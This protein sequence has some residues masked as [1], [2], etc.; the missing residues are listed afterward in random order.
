M[1][2]LSGIGANARSKHQCTLVIALVRSS[3]YGYQM[4]HISIRLEQ[5]YSKIQFF[6]HFYHMFVSHTG[7]SYLT[8]ILLDS[9]MVRSPAT[10]STP[11]MDSISNWWPYLWRFVRRSLKQTSISSYTFNNFQQLPNNSVILVVSQHLGNSHG[12]MPPRFVQFCSSLMRASLPSIIHTHFTYKLIPYMV[13]CAKC[14][15]LDC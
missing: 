6:I 10:F 2:D 12:A 8:Y 14:T 13:G 11:S 1:S 7:A 15:A 3:F 9:Q 5:T 4:L